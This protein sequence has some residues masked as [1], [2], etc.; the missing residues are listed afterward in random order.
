LFG[1]FGG[2]QQCGGGIGNLVGEMLGDGSCGNKPIFHI[3]TEKKWR[4]RIRRYVGVIDNQLTTPIFYLSRLKVLQFT[5][6]FRVRSHTLLL[7]DSEK[8]VISNT[9]DVQVSQDKYSK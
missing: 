7:A 8:L 2:G 4:Q 6:K 5:I 3:T 1:S 9:F